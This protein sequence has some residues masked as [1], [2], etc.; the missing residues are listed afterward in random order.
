MRRPIPLSP[1]LSCQ[2][3]SQQRGLVCACTGATPRQHGH[4]DTIALGDGHRARDVSRELQ[5]LLNRACRP[6]G[7]GHLVRPIQELH[8]QLRAATTTGPQPLLPARLSEASTRG[9]GLARVA[10]STVRA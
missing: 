1:R 5:R 3:A 4:A 6:L 2:A 10:H 8:L 9:R 7:A